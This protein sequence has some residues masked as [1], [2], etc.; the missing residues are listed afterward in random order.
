MQK[1]S[2]S[3]TGRCIFRIFLLLVLVCNVLVILLQCFQGTELLSRLPVAVL[4]VSGGSMEPSLHDGDGLLT[5]RTPFFRLKPG[6]V[7]TF[8]RDGELIT[9]KVI[10]LRE[11]KLI[12]QGTANNVPDDPVSE[13]DYCARVLLRLP[14]MRAL[15]R[16]YGSVPSFLVFTALVVLLI[17]GSDIF[18]T[19]YSAILKRKNKS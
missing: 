17:F 18:P 11:G 8:A 3:G 19:V 12:T 16:I 5:V 2:K 10:A 7:V 15:W 9:H 1:D 13:T 6:D 14:R 4:E